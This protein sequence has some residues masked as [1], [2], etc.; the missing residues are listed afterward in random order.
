MTSRF[1]TTLALGIQSHE[2]YYPGS[3]S[4]RNNN[5]GNIRYNDSLAKFY[6]AV[7]GDLG[8]ARF[9]TYNDGFRALCDD[10]SAKICGKSKNIDYSKNP[11]FLDMMK[12]YAP[13][14][15]H[16]DPVSYCNALCAKLSEFH[17]TPQTLLSEMCLLVNGKIEEIPEE[18][19][20]S[21][22]P[23]ARL[24]GLERRAENTVNP[25]AKNLIYSVIARL[26]LRLFNS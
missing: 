4:S 25:S 22:T 15:D 19:E 16:N 13:Q 18:P 14:A 12:V 21:V 11:T 20:V 6:G 5:P 17:I 24:K 1:L 23:E 8:F 10:L 2:G 7:K 26:K 9:R 3:A